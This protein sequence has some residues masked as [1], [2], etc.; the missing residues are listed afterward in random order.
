[1]LFR[2]RIRAWITGDGPDSA[3][4]DVLARLSAVHGQDKAMLQTRQF[5]NFRNYY[6]DPS[7]TPDMLNTIKAK[8][9]I[10]H[11]DDDFVPLDQAL[12]MKKYLPNGRLWIFPSGGH[13]P[14]LTP[15]NHDDFLRRTTEFF[16]RKWEQQ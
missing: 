13:V 9:L 16:T 3:K 10:V 7:F 14:H 11:S 2:S 5:W 8:W 12:E 6:G 15:Q 1:M 4:A